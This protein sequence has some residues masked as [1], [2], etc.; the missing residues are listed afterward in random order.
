MIKTVV[1]IYILFFFFALFLFMLYKYWINIKDEKRNIRY[2]LVTI[3][4]T[5]LLMLLIIFSNPL[6][7]LNQT[8]IDNKKIAVFLDNSKSV[9]FLKNSNDFKDKISL[10]ENELNMNNVESNIY[11]FGDSIRNLTDYSK[12]DFN[13]SSTDINQVFEA[14]KFLNYNE[15]ILISDGMQNQGLLDFLLLP[16]V[17]I[18]VF[19]LNS[20]YKNE[21]LS[22]ND[23]S[24]VYT[25]KDSI[26][27]KTKILSESTYNYNSIL[28][29][30]SNDKVNNKDLG[31]VDIASDKK[32]FFN[33]FI[34]SKSDLSSNNII[35][36][37]NIDNES[38]LDNNY[39]NF[40]LDLNSLN[41]KKALLFSGRLSQ[42]TKYIKSLIKEYPN[43]DL[44]HFYNLYEF[45]PN[46]VQIDQFDIIILDSFPIS[47]EHLKIVKEYKFFK[48]K[49]IV[50]LK[51]PSVNDDYNYYNEY[52]FQW[53]YVFNPEKNG[54]IVS[55]N[56]ENY[57]LYGSIINK[58]APINTDRKLTNINLEK[59]ILYDKNN[60]STLIDY[61]D[62]NLFLFIPNLSKASNETLSIY[63]TD[64]LKFLIN[65]LFKK[66]IFDFD[67]DRP[68]IY[69][70]NKSP[71]INN[72]FNLYMDLNKINSQYEKIKFFIYN[73]DGSIYS[74]I[75]NCSL[76]QD[77]VY[78]CT[79]SLN[80]AGKYFVQAQIDF[81]NGYKLSSNQ[82]ELII[83]DLDVETNNL[84]LNQKILEDISLNYNGFYSSLEE[85]N[86]YVNSIKPESYVSLDLSEILIFNFQYFWFLIILLLMLEWAIRKNK[87]L[88]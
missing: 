80:V 81:I 49:N 26:H 4:S 60:S 40:T 34:I 32:V 63:N 75:N 77:K 85:L 58:I 79:S 71:Y 67:T 27:I 21:D 61:K 29:R 28:V 46:E 17:V 19:G 51:G 41:R 31:Y 36:I 53:G 33:D 8:I 82:I 74:E 38:N 44:Y 7:L 12:I 69:S 86:N 14:V 76:N 13:D 78:K 66:I 16:N 5:V 15:Y 10:L 68:V 56:T 11:L 20:N 72:N 73:K 57:N 18:N 30:L 45:N 65:L 9:S 42:N 87:G 1:S 35:H 22:I 2:I 37:E 24:I 48:N 39:Y 3:R 52:L 6:F 64:N 59:S 83:N 62:N 25:S 84:G 43:I 55:Y 54:D 23:V 88:L 70:N 50:F 47:P